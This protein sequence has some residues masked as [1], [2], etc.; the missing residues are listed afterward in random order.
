MPNYWYHASFPLFFSCAKN[1][2]RISENIVSF[3]FLRTISFQII[4]NDPWFWIFLLGARQF[5][6]AYFLG[7][8]FC[9]SSVVVTLILAN[10]FPSGWSAT[11]KLNLTGFFHYFAFHQFTWASHA[12]KTLIRFGD[13]NKNTLWVYDSYSCPAFQVSRTS[14]C[15]WG[16]YFIYISTSIHAWILPCLRNSCY[17]HGNVAHIIWRK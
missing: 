7:F 2:E 4:L 17:F 10:N 3:I 9:S 5:S 12:P 11:F 16:E 14:E 8:R 1:S 13:G 6:T 15:W